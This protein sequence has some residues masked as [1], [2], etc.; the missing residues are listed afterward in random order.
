MELILD[1]PTLVPPWVEANS[2][3]VVS[4]FYVEDLLPVASIGKGNPSV[5]RKLNTTLFVETGND[6][7]L[8]MILS[9]PGL[10]R[11]SPWRKLDPL[12]LKLSANIFIY[13]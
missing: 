6:D 9:H 13:T 7:D 1:S 10:K 12:F 8:M 4:A 3:W 11:K 5:G 2:A